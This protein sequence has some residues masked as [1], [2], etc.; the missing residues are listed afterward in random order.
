[1]IL[2]SKIANQICKKNNNNKKLKKKKTHIGLIEKKKKKVTCYALFNGAILF[3]IISLTY[4]L[5]FP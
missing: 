4:F 1:M 5:F 2:L 3:F